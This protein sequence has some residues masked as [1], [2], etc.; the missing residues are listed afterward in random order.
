MA[1][2]AARVRVV[3]GRTS[4]VGRTF[5]VVP[6]DGSEAEVGVAAR[7]EMG[8]VNAE[9]AERRKKMVSKGSFM[10]IVT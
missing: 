2:G 9:H 6:E 8:V 5:S 4:W 1:A 3:E 10:V 7:L